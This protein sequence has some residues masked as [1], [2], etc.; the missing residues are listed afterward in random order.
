[1]AKKGSSLSQTKGGIYGDVGSGLTTVGEA[2]ALDMV[3][4]TGTSNPWAQDKLN[5]W[6][7]RAKVGLEMRPDQG[8]R[9]RLEGSKTKLVS[10]I[11]QR[12]ESAQPEVDKAY[13]IWRTQAR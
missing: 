8:A 9:D 13:R 1:M 5:R 10:K 4:G 3:R 7:N 12:D 6:D 11:F 2:A